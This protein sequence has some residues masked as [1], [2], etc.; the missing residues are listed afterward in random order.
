[1]LWTF[2]DKYWLWLT[3]PLF[4]VIIMTSHEI[5]YRMGVAVRTRQP[6]VKDES[7]G[8]LTGSAFGLLG[9]IL[10]FS[11]GWSASRYDALRTGRLEEAQAITELY[12]L[13]DL[14]PAEEH[15]RLQALLLDY[16][17]AS[18]DG[19]GN[20]VAALRQRETAHRELWKIATTAAR[21]SQT[22]EIGAAFLN[23]ATQVLNAHFR[24]SVRAVTSTIPRSIVFGVVGVL[25][26]TMGLVG[27]RAGWR[28]TKR[29]RALMPV[30][31][32]LALVVFLIADLN[33]PIEGFA[34]ISHGPLLEAQRELREWR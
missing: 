5:G 32:S 13:A 31:V 18:L 19:G 34:R 8:D 30:A 27:Y 3:I 21:T 14:L 12:R 11:F 25:V 26:C 20:V 29:S 24:R 4:V 1:M 10:A 23:A 2:F 6:D 16:I 9:L 7:L 22:P 15:S 17:A 28:G 33:R